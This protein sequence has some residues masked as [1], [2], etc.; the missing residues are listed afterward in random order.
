MKA[1]KHN[2]DVNDILIC[3]ID[4]Y[5]DGNSDYF[6]GN[7]IFVCEDGVELLYLSGYSSR[8]DFVPWKNIVA[9]VDK[10]KEWVDLG[11][12]PYKGHFLEFNK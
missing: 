4:E 2:I 9:K 5:N 7:V 11:V 1:S 8:R 10:D 12:I 6:D 3:K